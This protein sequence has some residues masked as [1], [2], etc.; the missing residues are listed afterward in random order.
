VVADNSQEWFE[1]AVNNKD[2][3]KLAGERF[4]ELY[5]QKPNPSD[6]PKALTRYVTYDPGLNDNESKHEAN[7]GDDAPAYWRK[8]LAGLVNNPIKPEPK[9]TIL[10]NGLSTNDQGTVLAQT[11]SSN[12][13]NAPALSPEISTQ[14]TDLPVPPEDAQALANN[15]K[16]PL[17]PSLAAFKAKQGKSSPQ[18][19]QGPT[20][21]QQSPAP[22]PKLAGNA[23]NKAA[24]LSGDQAQGSK[25]PSVS[26]VPIPTSTPRLA[27]I[28]HVSNKN[29][30]SLIAALDEV[31][32]TA[33]DEPA[34]NPNNPKPGKLSPA[35]AQNRLE[36]QRAQPSIALHN[37][38]NL[39]L[40]FYGPPLNNNDKSEDS[41]ARQMELGA[42]DVH[43]DYKVG[44]AVHAVTKSLKGVL[45]G[46][47]TPGIVYF[48]CST[49]NDSKASGDDPAISDNDGPATKGKGVV[50]S[51]KPPQGARE[52]QQ[53]QNL[54]GL[55]PDVIHSDMDPR[56]AL[57]FFPYK[58]AGESGPYA[59][60]PLPA[61][62]LQRTTDLGA[63][64][65]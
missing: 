43:K 58:D 4:A 14:L 29:D 23:N 33:P 10:D 50:D 41:V 24:R 49:D 55:V 34:V 51:A 2:N 37:L 21:N 6:Q 60:G 57:G 63:A 27:E 45:L 3:A 7:S 65:C 18:L 16:T 25:A 53:L 39:L 46:S 22:G 47:L 5:A 52:A 64:N 31:A 15:Q 19:A 1:N 54:A 36:A 56:V 35:D 17:K 38:H 12:R 28:G 30:G 61:A 13:N 59:E 40:S 9:K 48:Y 32:A 62:R 26:P 20:P 11:A 42:H 8:A 44:A